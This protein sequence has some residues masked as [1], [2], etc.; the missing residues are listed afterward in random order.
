MEYFVVLFNNK[1]VK[2]VATL[3]DAMLFI[4]NREAVIHRIHHKDDKLVVQ[5]IFIE[6]GSSLVYPTQ[7]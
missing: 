5:E 3:L 4:S 2:V 6:L 7:K 1:P